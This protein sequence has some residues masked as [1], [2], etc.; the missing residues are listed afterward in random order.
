VRKVLLIASLIGCSLGCVRAETL[1]F[2]DPDGSTAPR[3]G[4]TPPVEDGPTLPDAHVDAGADALPV[5]VLCG[6]TTCAAGYDC[7]D[8]PSDDCDPAEAGVCPGRCLPAATGKNC[9]GIAGLQC[10]SGEWCDFDGCGGIDAL[11]NCRP[12]PTVIDC[13]PV[14]TSSCLHPIC[15]CDGTHYGCDPCAANRAGSDSQR[16][17]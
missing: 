5:A 2:S 3:D 17:N 11:G 10:K 12:Q 6:A 4:S 14:S 7:I 15:G 16:C 1:L 13:P 9:G 8:D